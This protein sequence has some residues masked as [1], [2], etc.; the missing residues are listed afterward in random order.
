MAARHFACNGYRIPASTLARP[1]YPWAALPRSGRLGPRRPEPHNLRKPSSVIAAA[2]WYRDCG[3]H[4]GAKKGVAKGCQG[5]DKSF[6]GEK[7]GMDQKR[8]PAL[9][10][11]TSSL[12]GEERN[13][14]YAHL[15]AAK[16]NALLTCLIN[17]GLEKRVGTWGHTSGSAISGSTVADLGRDGLL[18]IN[19]KR[20]SARLT[21]RGLVAM[22]WHQKAAELIALKLE[23]QK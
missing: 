12:H 23:A 21:D 17:D 5:R 18:A 16:K 22:N 6:N 20:N 9:A 7:V 1:S 4:A 15:S 8:L 3:Y 10:T 2:W 19:S 13:R 14:I 11:A